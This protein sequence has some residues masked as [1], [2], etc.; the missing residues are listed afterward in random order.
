MCHVFQCA[1]L[2]PAFKVREFSVTD[3]QPYPI[4]LMWKDPNAD[5]GELE[6]FTEFHAVPFSK[7]LTFYRK[8]PF[9]IDSRYSYPNNIPYD[10]PRIGRFSIKNITPT[11]EGESSKVKVKVRINLHGIFTVSS[12]SMLEKVDKKTEADKAEEPMDLEGSEAQPPQEEESPTQE[13]GPN[14]EPA[15]AAAAAAAA[16]ATPEAME[17]ETP[18][19]QNAKAE[20]NETEKTEEVPA[21]GKP[22]QRSAA[23]AEN[24]LKNENRDSQSMRETT[25][26]SSSLKLFSTTIFL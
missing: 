23:D 25:S 26:D 22:R 20:K 10:N 9:D 5:D 14:E 2:S 7:M 6:V 12:A 18:S 13:N 21:E 8:E 3:L 19:S 16:G 1:M 11:P 17:Q 24:A 4:T 15:A